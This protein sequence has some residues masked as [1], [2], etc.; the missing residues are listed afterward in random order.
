MTCL[1]QVSYLRLH[2]VSYLRLRD[3]LG[4]C[5]SY[6]CLSNT[7]CV[8]VVIQYTAVYLVY[9][10]HI[11]KYHYIIVTVV[12]LVYCIIAVRVSWF[13]DHRACISD[14][15][16]SQMLGVLEINEK[17]FFRERFGAKYLRQVSYLLDAC[18]HLT[19]VYPVQRVCLSQSSISA[20]AVYLTQ[21]FARYHIC[22]MRVFILLLSIRYDVCVCRNPVYHYITATAVYLTQRVF[23]KK[24]HNSNYNV[25]IFWTM[26]STRYTRCVRQTAVAVISTR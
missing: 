24:I 4:V 2:Q 15:Q 10:C 23:C 1:Y 25:A 21:R 6:C 18:V 11:P 17:I 26:T 9:I 13:C 8:L 19:A 3:E 14:E 7:T 5:L 20:T 22:L 16:S 12:Y